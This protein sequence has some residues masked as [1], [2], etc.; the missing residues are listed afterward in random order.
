MNKTT[1]KALYHLSHPLVLLS[2]IALFI[3][4][5]ILRIYWPSWITGKLGDFAWL[6]FTPFVAI[7]ILAFLIPTSVRNHEKIVGY[8]SFSFVG[9]FFL[10]GNSILSTNEFLVES[11]KRWFSIQVQIT[12]DPTD[13]F[14]LISCAFGWRFWSNSE[15][16]PK[17][18][19]QKGLIIIPASALLTI[20]NM[21]AQD[22]GI[23]CFEMDG[24]SIYASSGYSDFISIDGGE[25]WSA[26]SDESG[27]CWEDRFAETQ[28][29][30]VGDGITLARV[31]PGKPIEISTDSG[32]SW[33]VE[34]GNKLGSQ[35]QQSY[36]EKFREGNPQFREGP[37]DAIFDP[38][39]GNFIFAMGHEGVLIRKPDKSWSWIGVGTYHR[40]DYSSP[41]FYLL[42]WGEGLLAIANGLLIFAVLGIKYLK[43]G[44]KFKRVSKNILTVI[45][46]LSLGIAT[47]VF[48]S[49]VAS[50]YATM[51]SSPII[52]FTLF[53]LVVLSILTGIQLKKSEVLLGELIR[54][55][56]LG[57]CLFIIPYLLW[58]INL[59]P[60]YYFAP[61]IAIATQIG[62]VIICWQKIETT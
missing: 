34:F 48:P 62:L 31:E 33:N 20:A 36:Y 22:F 15:S 11:L 8:L 23:Y 39:S 55:S 60:L 12:R 27:I 44:S 1:K 46:W 61:V 3:N 9:I 35:A 49:A 45:A 32:N 10:L 58:F 18:N 28:I 13:L 25:N 4:D 53:F 43:D 37:L 21:A 41:N 52:F 16:P 50:G 38:V 26:Y 57:M 40:I 7:A 29:V 19:L 30:E 59:L 6:F 56:T 24:T 54:I 47:I 2:I 14:A 5:H 51:P 17:G 42:L